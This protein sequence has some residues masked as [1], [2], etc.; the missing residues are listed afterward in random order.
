MRMM[1]LINC[2][3]NVIR[4]IYPILKDARI[5]SKKKK[6]ACDVQDRKRN[7]SQEQG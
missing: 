3:C 6:A 1:E 7:T 4:A 5:H 2:V